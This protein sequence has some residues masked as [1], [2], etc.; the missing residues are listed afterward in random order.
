MS[1]EK[2]RSAAEAAPT[3]SSQSSKP[4][5]NADI[6]DVTVIG[7]GLAGSV[8]SIHLA[9][10]GFKVVLLE[11]E[12]A[13][14][15]KV[16]GE[17]LS[18]EAIPLLK[19]VGLDPKKLGAEE[20]TSFRLHGPRL[21]IERK[22]PIKSIGIS[23]KRLDE[24]LLECAEAA[25]V[26][27]RRGVTA[28]EIIDGLESPSGSIL[29]ETSEGE[30]RSR[31]LVVATGKTDFKSVNDREARDSGYVGFK[32]HL[33]L[34]PSVLKAM[35]KHCDLFVFDGGHGGISPIE[36]DLANFCFMIE[37]KALKDIGTDWESLASHIAKNCW[38]ASH[39]LDGAEPQFKQLVTVAN[40][41]Y[42]FVRRT[43]PP[44]GLFF[45][46][47]QMATIPS[48]TGDG[49]TIALLTGKLAADAIIERV[50]GKARLRFAPQASVNYQRA[51]RSRL[52]P[53]VE[54]GFYL[55][56]LFKKPLF[57]DVSIRATRR[58]P[59]LLDAVIL[60]T[61]CRIDVPPSTRLSFRKSGLLPARS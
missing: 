55:H 52:R 48:L 49:M 16:C 27:V 1:R 18:G 19:E 30:L 29:L 39:Y 12:R 25:G 50:A 9:R 34:K 47:D 32:M 53:Q 20:I 5:K 60:A 21:S 38:A 10:A 26:D 37:R 46:G 56:R 14:L 13:S 59:A 61:R 4:Y 24:K 2:K 43:P 28:K 36:G 54:T 44:A 23:R 45:V 6:C 57:V 51:M 33:R 8:A 40:V 58:I 15:D 41:P 42:G 35:K 11:K 17:F 22:L 3:D 31:R 7:G